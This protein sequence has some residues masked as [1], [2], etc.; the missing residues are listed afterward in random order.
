MDTGAPSLK[1]D[2]ARLL[3]GSFTASS[4]HRQAWN[5]VRDRCVC[6][7]MCVCQDNRKGAVG[8]SLVI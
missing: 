7:C 4:A 1:T 6:L 8:L 2:A 3:G 5:T